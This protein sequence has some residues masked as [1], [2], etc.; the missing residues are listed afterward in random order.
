MSKK[1]R[2]SPTV[3]PKDIRK[4]QK[5][6]SDNE[7]LVVVTG[8]GSTYL[9]QKF[10]LQII[11]PGIIWIILGL[12]LA[13]Y[14]KFNPGYGLLLGMI[15]SCLFSWLQTWITYQSHRYLL[16]NRRVIIKEGFVKIKLSSALYDK[17]THIE[18]VQGLVDR[19]FL[20]HGKIIINTA[21]S[22][23]DELVLDFVE[24]PIQFKNILERLIHQER[25]YFR[26]S[27]E[28]LEPIEGEVI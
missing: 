20:K 23:K 17:V 21:G 7:E 5:Y 24:E 25:E 1:V 8:Y 9:R 12:V 11:L 28:K 3:D 15:V 19:L 26:S 13:I 27:G 18:V 14:Q 6:L 10:I 16:T 2:Y 4:F 22:N